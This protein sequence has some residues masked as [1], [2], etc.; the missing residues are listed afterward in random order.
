M[1]MKYKNQVKTRTPTS[2]H[3][4]APAQLK[5]TT[6]TIWT[7]TWLIL[8]FCRW[9]I[10]VFASRSCSDSFIK[11]ERGR[12]AKI[13]KWPA[14]KPF[15][16]TQSKSYQ[17]EQHHWKLCTW[18][19]YFAR[20]TRTDLEEEDDQESFFRWLEENPNAGVAQNAD[21]DDDQDIEYDEDGNIIVPEK[22]K[23]KIL[24]IQ[25]SRTQVYSKILSL[26]D[27]RPTTADWSLTNQLW[28]FW[29]KFLRRTWGHQKLG[30]R[31][32]R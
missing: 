10:F 19:F 27:Y 9:L 8:R 5:V 20:G 2:P 16:K 32:N 15:P 1:K 30:K 22:S 14:R 31:R 21:N 25:K 23:V 6:K 18:I 29:K 28:E 13:W 3:L 4:E 7:C 11:F 26:E 12:H 17:A 24:C